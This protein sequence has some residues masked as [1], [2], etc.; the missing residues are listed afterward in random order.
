MSQI[1]V[2]HSFDE[3]STLREVI[4]GS[5]AGYELHH[6]DVSFAL[7]YFENIYAPLRNRKGA[8][9]SGS[10]IVAIPRPIV[11]EAQEDLE[12]LVTALR[13]FGATVFRP[14]DLAAQGQIASPSW[15]SQST[16]ALNVRDQALILGSTILETAP[17]VRGRIFENDMLKPIFYRYFNAGSAWLSMPRPA[18]AKG[19]LDPSYF[20][21]SELDIQ[22]ALERDDA[23]LIPGLGHEIIFDAA[24]CIRLSRDVLVNVANAN[25]EMGYRWLRQVF[26]RNFRF[27]RIYQAA[28]NHI[29]SVL[30]PLRPGVMLLR[31]PGF[32]QLLPPAMRNWDII[33]PPEGDGASFP[34]YRGDMLHIASRYIDMNVLS[35]DENTVIVNALYPELV[36]QLERRRFDVIPVRLRHG[37]LF[38]GGF[39]CVT[40]DCVRDGGLESYLG[41]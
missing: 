18:L 34:E 10:Q 9:G 36:R 4:V 2:V 22:V 31:A 20:A 25:H 21:D 26:G 6:L 40:L 24:Q 13:D 39:H 38:G 29:D 33:Y 8:G 23:Q 14:A 28:D 12:E 16:P 11:A 15:T 3:W 1:R 7:F 17:H 19:S 41:E 27:H 30:A 37:R 35:L 32:L 5:V